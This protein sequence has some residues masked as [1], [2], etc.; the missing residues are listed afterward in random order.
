MPAQHPVKRLRKAVFPVGGLGTR[1]LPATKSMPKE[2]LPVASKPLIQYAFEE[3]LAA[4]IEQFIFVT[5]RNKNAISNHFDHS[6]ELQQHL[7]EKDKARELG[8]ARE[9]LPPAGQVAFVRQQ[10]PLGLGHAVWCARNFIGD[11]PFAVLLADEMLLHK[12]GFLKEMA[13]LYN[14]TGGNIIGLAEVEREHI[15]RYGI[16][17]PEQHEGGIIRIRGMVEKPEPEAAPSN[18]C[19]IGRYILQP[20]IFSYLERGK[21]GSGGE[22][23]LT[24]SM[25]DMLATSPFYGLPFTGRR[26]DCGNPLGF[27]EAN[28]AYALEQHEN[29][30][31]VKKMLQEFIG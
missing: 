10:E 6:Y 14:E 5:G 1:F 26:F 18:L 8:L 20:E 11:E 29:T 19:I 17:D 31:A 23:Q 7:S 30:A 3:A 25:A 16:I 21:R 15:K 27:L 28:I 24:D 2:M 13:T 4:G 22:I 9:W 12:G